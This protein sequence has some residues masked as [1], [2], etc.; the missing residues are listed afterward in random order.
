[1]YEKL[2]DSFSDNIEVNDYFNSLS[3]E[4]SKKSV[5]NKKANLKFLLG[6]PGSGKTFLINYLIQKE[7]EIEYFYFPRGFD[8]KEEFFVRL[9]IKNLEDDKN[10]F[11]DKKHLII[12]DEAQLLENSLLE[13]IRTLSDTKCFNFLLSTHL[14]DGKK[15][16]SKQHFKSREIDIIELDPISKEEMI[17]FVNKKLLTFNEDNLVTKSDFDDIYKFTNGNFRYI[18][19]FMK[20]SFELLQFAKENKIEKYTKIDKCIVTMAG[21]DLG[22]IDE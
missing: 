5:L 21:L 14:D 1:M 22:L 17:R 10:S 19:R 18:K 13:Y 11:K 4:I 12:I 9:G 6:Q 15:I 2:I 7:E 8:S 20:K 3:F 16:L